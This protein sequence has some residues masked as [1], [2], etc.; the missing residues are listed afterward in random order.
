MIN[1]LKLVR[2]EML[3]ITLTPVV[4]CKSI[5]IIIIIMISS[6]ISI[7]ILIFIFERILL[8]NYFYCIYF[9]RKYLEDAFAY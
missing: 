4:E 9:K 3:C 6:I 7:I 5:F 2:I 8:R 1:D